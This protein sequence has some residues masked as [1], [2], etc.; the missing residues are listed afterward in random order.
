LLIK[1]HGKKF[2]RQKYTSFATLQLVFLAR[3]PCLI[4]KLDLAF[5]IR[6]NKISLFSLN[7]NDNFGWST[8][9]LQTPVYAAKARNVSQ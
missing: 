5:L 8:G 3:F 9:D 1:E 6:K 7:G 2:L 4:L